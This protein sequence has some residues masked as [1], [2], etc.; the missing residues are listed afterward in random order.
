MMV[1]HATLEVFCRSV[2]MIYQ[3]G[4][5]VTVVAPGE[6]QAK[7]S[8]LMDQH[9]AM[10]GQPAQAEFEAAV[11]AWNS[12]KAVWTQSVRQEHR[13]ERQKGSGTQVAVVH[14]RY[15]D[16][17]EE[18]VP[19]AAARERI[20]QRFIEANPMPAAPPPL[21]P[22]VAHLRIAIGTEWRALL[23]R[24][25]GRD[26]RFAVSGNRFTYPIEDVMRSLDE[27]TAEGWQ[28]LSVSE[29]RFVENSESFV[30]AVRY[31]LARGEG[32][33]DPVP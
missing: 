8:D 23:I 19:R 31:L 14:L 16:G 9:A 3:G 26:V 24:A 1:S 30:Q 4:T 28:L 27:L 11:A 7:L 32:G 6:G 29:D 13:Y 33:L 21:T 18:T 15:P 5:L 17:Y 22:E 10:A 25:S 2:E 12:S 20:E